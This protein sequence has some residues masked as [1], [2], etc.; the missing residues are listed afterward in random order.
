MPYH[1]KQATIHD[2][3]LLVPLF[4]GYRVFYQQAS[5]PAAA[6]AFLHARFEHNQSV[7]F[8]AIDSD[9][10]ALAQG[11]TQLYPSF[12]SVSLKRLWIL[13]DLF[14]AP[15]SRGLGIGE[16]LLQAAEAF[17]LATQAKGL[18]LSTAKTNVVAQH[19][20]HKAGW[21]QDEEFLSYSRY[22]Q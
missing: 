2:L 17:S 21:L 1:I 14:V 8:L 20:Y 6:R 7:V 5:D 22:H 11:F 13:N 15:D 12:S 16:A 4:D 10:P 3:D 18:V 9:N 19:R